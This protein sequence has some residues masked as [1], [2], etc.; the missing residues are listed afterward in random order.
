MGS[1]VL[2]L[3]RVLCPRTSGAWKGVGETGLTQTLNGFRCVDRFPIR[4][5]SG[6]W[7]ER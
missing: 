7:A 1:E 6:V 4:F 5:W 3:F 2:V